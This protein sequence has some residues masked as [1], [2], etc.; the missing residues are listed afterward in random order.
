[1]HESSHPTETTAA[2]H[3]QRGS[4]MASNGEFLTA[5]SEFHESIRFEPHY[6]T[7]EYLGECLVRL[8]RYSEA[9]IYFAAATY[10]DPEG[11]AHCQ[12]RLA[13]SLA[14]AGREREAVQAARGA[15][16][17][18]PANAAAKAVLERIS[19]IVLTPDEA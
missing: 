11:G 5:V 18:D 3:F 2:K 8:Q 1:M 13:E 7:S 15:L 14:L 19:S 6:K 9:I 17:F 10:L 16:Q 4:E 12:T